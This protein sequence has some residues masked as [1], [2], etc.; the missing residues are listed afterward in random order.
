MSP[1]SYQKISI[2]S[3]V[4]FKKH[5]TSMSCTLEPAIWSRDT[6]QPIPCLDRCQLL[7]TWMFK[8]KEVHGKPRLHLSTNLLFGVWP[9]CCATPSPFVRTRPR[10]IPLPMT[11]MRKSVHGFHFPYMVMGLRL[12]ALRAARAPLQGKQLVIV[13]RAP[14]SKKHYILV[15]GICA[16]EAWIAIRYSK[17]CTGCTILKVLKLYMFLS[18]AINKR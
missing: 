2:W 12:A 6:G 15:L 17:H 18:R 7:I 4:N 14:D 1:R 16:W 5:M 11:T 13:H 3:L 10:K 9:Q 8:I